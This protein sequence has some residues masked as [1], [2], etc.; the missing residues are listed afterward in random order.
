MKQTHRITTPANGVQGLF[1]IDAEG[2]R[3]DLMGLLGEF[4]ESQV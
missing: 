3:L 1:S 2:R 4:L